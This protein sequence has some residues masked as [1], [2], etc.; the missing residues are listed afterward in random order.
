LLICGII[1]LFAL[2]A[3]TQNFEKFSFSLTPRI[4]KDG[5]ITDFT[6]G[7]EYTKNYAGE[8]R[9]R[10]SKEDKNEQFANLE[11]SL[12][13]ISGRNFEAYLLPVEYSFYQQNQMKLR[14]GGG[15]YYNYHTLREKGYF[16]IPAL[17]LLGKEKVN[18]FSNNLSMHTIGPDFDIG[19]SSRSDAFSIFAYGGIVPVFYLSSHQKM[20]IVPLLVPN[21]ADFKQHTYGSPYVYADV[22]FILFKYISL[23][24]LYDFSRLDY[25]VIDFD[26]TLNWYKP[27]R[28]VVSHSLKIEASLLIPLEGNTYTQIG[29]GHTFDSVQ[30]DSDSPVRNSRDY[31]IFSVK[32]I[33]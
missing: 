4:L 14:V 6:F 18:S 9:L 1:A 19:F 30:L 27:D 33:Q 24:F 32:M 3:Y 31:I 10:F 2:P 25:K 7:Y 22:N 17:A 11:D 8:L 5:T 13:A 26:D 16:N 12:N 21:Y 23:S 20:G 15:V 28:T 29:Y